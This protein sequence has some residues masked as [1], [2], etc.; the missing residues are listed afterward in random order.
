MGNFG[1]FNIILPSPSQL[2]QRRSV[3]DTGSNFVTLED[4]WQLLILDECTSSWLLQTNGQMR[5]M[6]Y[7]SGLQGH[8]SLSDVIGETEGNQTLLQI[9][10]TYFSYK[11]FFYFDFL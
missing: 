8:F 5:G 9:R 4:T 2:H 1:S 10:E 11:F 7:F 3:S 6:V